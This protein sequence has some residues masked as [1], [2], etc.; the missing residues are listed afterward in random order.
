[1][2]KIIAKSSLILIVCAISWLLI[3]S[4]SLSQT[5]TSLTALQQ[6]LQTGQSSNELETLE[7]AVLDIIQ[8]VQAIETLPVAVN[9]TQFSATQAQIEQKFR[10][11]DSQLAN[12]VHTVDEHSD[13]KDALADLRQ[14]LTQL[15]IQVETARQTAPNTSQDR[16]PTPARVSRSQSLTPHFNILGSEIRGGEQVLVIS[17][18]NDTGTIRLLRVGDATAEWTFTGITPEK[19]RFSVNNRPRHLLIP[20]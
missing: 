5:N 12:I 19:A 14:R 13:L 2:K 15:E 11:I 10:Q 3:L 1:M 17:P 18:K 8:R 7:T 4:L 16:S 6:E 9:Y 20:Q